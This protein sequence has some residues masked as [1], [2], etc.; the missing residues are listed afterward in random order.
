MR[1]GLHLKRSGLCAGFVLGL[2][3]LTLTLGGCGSGGGSTPSPAVTNTDSTS[4]DATIVTSA[5]RGLAKARIRLQWPD[6]SDSRVVPVAARSVKISLSQNGQSL[7]GTERLLVRPASGAAEIATAQWENLPVGDLVVQAT[8]YPNADGT[9]TPLAFASVVIPLRAD[10]EKTVALTLASTIDHL[11]F[12]TGELAPATEIAPATLF[13]GDTLPVAV[14]ALDKNGAVVLVKNT[15]Q[16]A[17]S[18]SANAPLTV[19]P[20]GLSATLSGKEATVTTVTVTETDSGKT[21]SVEIPVTGFVLYPVEVGSS[22]DAATINNQGWV[23]VNSSNFP[24]GV[25]KPPYTSLTQL[26]FSANAHPRTI[27]RP[28]T[29][30]NKGQIG[31]VFGDQEP[32]NDVR[33]GAY[34]LNDINDAASPLSL[35]EGPNGGNK[36]ISVVSLNDNNKALL[37][38]RELPTNT[39]IAYKRAVLDIGSGAITDVP[40]SVAYNGTDVPLQFS[41]ITNSNLLLGAATLLSNRT[42]VVSLGAVAR[43]D[44]AVQLITPVSGDTVTMVSDGNASGQV[45]G[46][47]FFNL[48]SFGGGGN[49][50]NVE[51]PTGA[52]DTGR[53]LNDSGFAHPFVWTAASGP[54][55][56]PTL[57]GFT[58]GSATGINRNGLIV[59]SVNADTYQAVAPYSKGV[60]WLNNRPHELTALLTGASADTAVL[61]ANRISDTNYI[62]ARNKAIGK[63][64]VLVPVTRKP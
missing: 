41:Q 27:V 55:V 36:F 39:V 44:G 43:I 23:L 50:G 29:V 3:A 54:V 21:A 15:F 30:N 18:D 2:T 56:L 48:P 53:A 9:G 46:T 33:V 6:G 14:S 19:G 32:G 22:P 38:Y 51:E 28:Y 35:G 10:Q 8:A 47:S 31:G 7:A 34:I 4:G 37:Q 25:V 60:L 13:K 62:T 40:T 16:F 61:N 58:G 17:S 49:T 11:Q 52:F 5:G 59:G 63:P 12:T 20:D 42:V 64:C 24:T 57:P 1:S 45:V 26:S